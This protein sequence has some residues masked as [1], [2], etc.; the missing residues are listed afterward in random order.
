MRSA[1]SAA[2]CRAS[3]TGGEA[4]L[5]S[6]SSL[7][8]RSSSSSHPPRHS[9]RAPARVVMATCP[10]RTTYTVP[11]R[12]GTRSSARSR[13]APAATCL[14]AGTPPGPSGHRARVGGWDFDDL[15][16]QRDTLSRLVEAEE[17]VARLRGVPEWGDLPG[18]R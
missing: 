5:A 12:V 4:T 9:A 15:A 16:D 10:D 14:M 6:P 13:T 17:R 3:N 1:E 18:L 2:S 11:E 7:P 8:R